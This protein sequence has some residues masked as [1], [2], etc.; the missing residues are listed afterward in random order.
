MI[1]ES[2]LVI[3]PVSPCQPAGGGA[4][5]DDDDEEASYSLSSRRAGFPAREPRVPTLGLV[6]LL[7]KNGGCRQGRGGGGGGG[8]RREREGRRLYKRNGDAGRSE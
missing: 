3:D 7:G 2:Y 1:R 4:G 6:S 8:G 5:D